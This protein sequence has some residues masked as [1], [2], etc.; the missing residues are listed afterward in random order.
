LSS[1]IGEPM[2][3]DLDDFDA[4]IPGWVNW[5][6]RAASRLVGP[7][8]GAIDGAGFS[9]RRRQLLGLVVNQLAYHHANRQVMERLDHR[10]HVL[11]AT[12][13][14]ATLG[15]CLLLLAFKLLHGC[16]G[17]F[18]EVGGAA[19]VALPAFGAA[20]F[21]IRIQLD[22]AGIARRSE[23]LCMQLESLR[24]AITSDCDDYVLLLDRSR[25]LAQIMVSD[26]SDWRVT[27]RGRPFVLPA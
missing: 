11:G 21:G 7:P 18:V 15:M 14:A 25:R 5:R 9:A 12:F 2:L 19:T 13:F 4:G 3:R 6:T 8:S 17:L 22:F 20:M 1:W 26:I 10:T 16:D 24:N 23:R 27:Y